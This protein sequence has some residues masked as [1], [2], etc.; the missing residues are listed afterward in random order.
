MPHTVFNDKLRFAA[1]FNENFG[2]TGGAGDIGKAR[3]TQ[4]GGNSWASKSLGLDNPKIQGFVTGGFVN[5]VPQVA[6]THPS[7]TFDFSCRYPIIDSLF[8]PVSL[9]LSEVRSRGSSYVR[10][11][12]FNHFCC[13]RTSSADRIGADLVGDPVLQPRY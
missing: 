7:N 6:P 10:V 9:S 4:D 1:F 11:A 8:L 2:V 5:E 3:V 12:V 13:L